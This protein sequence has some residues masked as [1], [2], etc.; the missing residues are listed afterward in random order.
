VKIQ[1]AGHLEH[2]LLAFRNRWVM[3]HVFDRFYRADRARSRDDGG[4]GLGLATLDR[5]SSCTAGLFAPKA[6]RARAR[7]ST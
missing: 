4:I 2:L 1:D 5:L 6:S 3:A 7:R